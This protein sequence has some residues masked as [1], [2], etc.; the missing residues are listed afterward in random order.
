MNRALRRVSLICLVLFV[1]LLVN[2]NWVQGFDASSLANEPGNGRTVSAT[3]QF[4]RG[5]ILTSDQKVVAFSKMN[6]NFGEYQRHYPGGPI[7]APV[8]GYDTLFSQTG[9]EG[10]AN[11]ELAGTDP[12]L[13]VHNLIDLIS[14]K[15]KKGATVTLT[16]NSA[17]QQAAYAALK[18]TGREAGVVA[19]NPQ[20][21]AIIAMASYPSF[22]PELLATLDGTKLNRNDKKLLA[23]PRHPLINNALSTT[24]PPGSTFKIVTSS[25]AF[26][27]GKVADETTPVF[28]PTKLTLP[29]TSTQLIN[30]NGSACNNGGNPSGNGKVPLI[31][32]FTVSCNTVFGALGEKLSATALQAEGTKYGFNNPGLTVAPG[33]QAAV[34]NLPLYKDPAQRAGAAIGQESDTVTPLQEAMLS[35][36]V[37]NNGTLMKPYLVQKVTAP[38]LSTIQTAT[39]S[40]LGTPLTTPQAQNLQAMMTSVV[41]STVGTAHLTAGTQVT[42]G[43]TIAGKTGTAQN[44]INNSGL[45]DAVFTSYAPTA[46]PQIAVGV[47]VKG[48]GF[49]ADAAAPIAVKVIEAYLN[50]GKG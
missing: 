44:G 36:T 11:K 5:S 35:A 29:G 43:I 16:V 38:D 41:S 48:G 21:G 7:Y 39:S 32:A 18:A 49:G 40:T 19:L 4:Q 2:I 45:D 47:V 37:A 33:M 17:A 15:P 3:L 25:T 27:T 13:E 31:Y 28:A 26:V 20:T 22:N 23:D 14:G 24:F 50:Q 12:A 10:A 1:A 6:K 34:S 9:I 46:N 8:T 42:G 30:D